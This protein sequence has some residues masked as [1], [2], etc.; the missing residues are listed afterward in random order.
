MAVAF[1]YGLKDGT[2]EGS[3]AGGSEA[4]FSGTE[5][6]RCSPSASAPLPLA[7]PRSRTGP[8]AGKAAAKPK[9]AKPAGL[10]TTK[11]AASAVLLTNPNTPTPTSQVQA[12]KGKADWPFGKDSPGI[13]TPPEEPIAPQET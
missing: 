5:G 12:A 8:A 7:E 6:T 4:G 11:Q 13:P 9:K 10:V 1:T 3:E 2:E